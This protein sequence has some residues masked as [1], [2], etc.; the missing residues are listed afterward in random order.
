MTYKGRSEQSER[1]GL[2]QSVLNEIMGV[3]RKV[4]NIEEAILYG[5]RA[6]GTYKPGSDVDVVLK[7]D[8]L[9]LRDINKIILDLDDLNLPYTFDISIY[10]HI[11]NPEL[12]EHIKRVGKN[13][14][15]RQIVL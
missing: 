13:I 14:Y 6:K 12:I 5:S 3:F 10:H 8:R 15:K 1:F 2:K 4:S 7:G 9:S 11:D